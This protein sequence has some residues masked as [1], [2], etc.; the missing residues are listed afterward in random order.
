MIGPL[1]SHDSLDVLKPL[2]GKPGAA[3]HHTELKTP[4][5]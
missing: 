3:T 4:S 5:P 2:P 1:K